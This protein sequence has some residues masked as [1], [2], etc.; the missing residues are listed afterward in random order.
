MA[1]GGG[2]CIEGVRLGRTRGESVGRYSKTWMDKR[3]AGGE[4]VS[5]W[6]GQEGN[7]QESAPAWAGMGPALYVCLRGTYSILNKKKNPT[8]HTCLGW[9]GP[10][11]V[12]MSERDVFN[13]KQ[14]KNPT[15]LPYPERDVFNPKQK[16][17]TDLPYPTPESDPKQK[18]PTDLP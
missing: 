17:P 16:T 3:M 6:E 9:D 13:P 14:K 11:S 5:I 7:G 4:E 1:G 15:D 18:N 12:C 2:C 8:E 10:C